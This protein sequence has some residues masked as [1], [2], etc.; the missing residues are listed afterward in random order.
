MT[1]WLFRRDSR[2]FVAYVETR[3]EAVAR[4]TK[5]LG[6]PPREDEV[7]EEPEAEVA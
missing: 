2:E 5:I 6:A 4:F 1:R 7:V 3:E